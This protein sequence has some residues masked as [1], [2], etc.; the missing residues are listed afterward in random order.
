MLPLSL[1]RPDF[2]R[3]CEAFMLADDKQA[4]K[5]GWTWNDHPVRAVCVFQSQSAQRSID[6]PSGLH[7]SSDFL[8]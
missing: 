8:A 6:I 3:A 4:W 7:V 5:K 2:D 1:T